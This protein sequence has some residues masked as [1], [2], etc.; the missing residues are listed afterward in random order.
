[1][2]LPSELYNHPWIFDRPEAK[3]WGKGVVV[4][5]VYWLNCFL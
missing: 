3:K 4:K 1:M 2:R 5:T